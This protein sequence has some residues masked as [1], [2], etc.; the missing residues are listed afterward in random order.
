MRAKWTAIIVDEMI[1]SELNPPNSIFW[2]LRHQEAMGTALM[3]F[4]PDLAE[5]VVRKAKPRGIL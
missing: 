2:S 4:K 1:R 5:S 3:Q